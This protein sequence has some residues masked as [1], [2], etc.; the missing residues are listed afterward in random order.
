MVIPSL[1]E[2]I[3]GNLS[4]QLIESLPTLRRRESSGAGQMWSREKCEELAREVVEQFDRAWPSN[5]GRCGPA[6]W[7]ESYLR[8]LVT[9]GKE[10]E[11]VKPLMKRLASL[12]QLLRCSPQG[13][14]LRQ[15]GCWA[16]QGAPA[17][18]EQH[19]KPR[20]WPRGQD[21]SAYVDKSLAHTMVAILWLTVNLC[22]P[23]QNLKVNI[24]PLYEYQW[25]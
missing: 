18:M 13:F 1:I 9:A 6:T 2:I 25:N 12:V 19:W 3:A 5:V 21:S 4:P 11:P 23:V 24:E 8:R 14:W 17:V 22:W 7:V 20:G 15:E 16:Q 10:Q